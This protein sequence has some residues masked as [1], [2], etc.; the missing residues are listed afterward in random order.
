[1]PLLSRTPCA[2]HC[3]VPEVFTKRDGAP[4]V[5]RRRSSPLRTFALVTGRVSAVARR[6]AMLY[7]V[8]DPRGMQGYAVG[9]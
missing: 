8:A 2:M 3:C 6:G 9:R 5:H 7:A 4:G 1:M